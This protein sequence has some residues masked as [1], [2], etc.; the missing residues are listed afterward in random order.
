[1]KSAKKKIQIRQ[2]VDINKNSYKI[3]DVLRKDAL[4]QWRY[5]RETYFSLEDALR[6]NTGVEI[7]DLTK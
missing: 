4:G 7:E 2:I 6:F 1:M 3:Y 5:N